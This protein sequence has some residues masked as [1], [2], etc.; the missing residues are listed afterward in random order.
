MTGPAPELECPYVGLAPFEAAHADYFFGRG[1]DSAVLADNVVARPI[2]VLYGASGVG[3]SSVLNVGLPKAL[4]ELGVAA[5]IV[6][7]R[8]WH[9]PG[10]LDAWLD[11]AIDAARAAPA[12]PLIVILDQFEEYFL[13]PDAEQVKGF[14]RSLAALVARTDIEAHL[15]FGL[16]DDG[17]HRLDALRVHLPGL[18][19]TTLELRHLDE[20]AVREAIEQPIVE[21]NK[22][23][24]PAVVLD[25]DFAEALIAQLRPKDKDGQPVE[26][27]RVELA[28]LQLALERIW[29]A[30]GGAEAKA[31][32]TSTLTERLK[33]IGEISRR[34]VEDVLG[35]LPEADQELCATVFDRLVTPSGG[36]ILYATADLAVVAKVAP[37]RM[38]DVLAPLASG[39]NRL[40]RAVELP[41]AKQA[42]GYEILHDILA[43]PI[44]DW[45][46]ERA[47]KLETKVERERADAE[48]KAHQRERERADAEARARRQAESDRA[49]VAKMR[50]W[51][52]GLAVMLLGALGLAAWAAWNANQQAVIAETRKK[53]AVQA[54][55]SERTAK[56]AAE[57]ALVIATD[58]QKK[59]EE[60]L[61]SVEAE[62]AK[63]VAAKKEAEQAAK[64]EKNAKADADEQRKFAEVQRANAEKALVAATDAQQKTEEALRSVEAEKTKA[65][66]AQQAAETNQ[67]RAERS[68]EAARASSLRANGLRLVAEAQG[69]LSGARS[70][71]DERGMLQLLA[72]ERI[73]PAAEVEGGLL[74]ALLFHRG[75]QKLVA[76]AAPVAAVAFSPD[77]RRIVSGSADK[78][79]RLWDANT[80]QPIGAPLEGH[81]RFGEERR[82][83]PRRPPHRLRQCG[84]DPAA[85]G[86]QHRPAHRRAARRAQRMRLRASPSAPT[87][88]ASSPAVGTTPC[89]C[90]TPTP[91]SP[92]AQP[93]KGT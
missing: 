63:A 13:Y 77:G 57:K 27:G 11:G 55:E 60:A 26:G 1:L 69:M 87:A 56:A 79:L 74:N 46:E 10:M 41:A 64:E 9:E 73:A 91:A 82:L 44:L 43:R 16:R 84:Q 22:R 30:E 52:V 88:A 76:T 68:E 72:A 49:R 19:D 8:E 71:G 92:S 7:R 33:G 12:R 78:T 53:E 31:L 62:T 89:A 83:Q 4:G 38:D 36:K 80:G 29:E 42:R 66:A 81:K 18:L 15:L 20:P 86:R 54:A 85:V 90:G 21:W 59:T 23:H 6:S 39:K 34:H 17:L 75:L 37:K 24:K 70:E 40:L 5:R 47:A 65:V 51:L 48:A 25:D 93:L 28:Y 45:K 2:V 32:R 58:A 35:K 67:E 3:K 61:R 14:A 50:N